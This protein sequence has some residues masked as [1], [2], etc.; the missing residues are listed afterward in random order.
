MLISK[1]PKMREITEKQSISENNKNNFFAINLYLHAKKQ[2]NINIIIRIKKIICKTLNIRK[3]F[4][5]NSKFL[6][7]LI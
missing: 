4:S 6:S 3:F 1:I 5:V 2:I 7:L